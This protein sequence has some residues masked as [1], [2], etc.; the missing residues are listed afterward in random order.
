MDKN[1][2][3]MLK[4][5]IKLNQENNDIKQQNNMIARNIQSP[6]QGSSLPTHTPMAGEP[7]KWDNNATVALKLL[8]ASCMN[9]GNVLLVQHFSYNLRNF[10]LFL[11]TPDSMK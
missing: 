1:L 2:V 7:I 8:Y 9:E 3:E 6:N 5:P 11:L 10:C 4:E